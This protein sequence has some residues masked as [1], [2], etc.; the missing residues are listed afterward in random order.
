MIID[1]I[2]FTAEEQE[3]IDALTPLIDQELFSYPAPEPDDPRRVILRSWIKERN[4]IMADVVD[5]YVTSITPDYAAIIG[6]TKEIIFAYTAQDFLSHVEPVQDVIKKELTRRQ[7]QLD[8]ETDPK[9]QRGI[10]ALIADAQDQ[11]SNFFSLTYIGILNTLRQLTGPENEA[12]KRGGHADNEYISIL[13]SRAREIEAE[14]PERIAAKDQFSLFDDQQESEKQTQQQGARKAAMAI[15]RRAAMEKGALM[16]IGG[17][18]ASYSED[19]MKDAL[20][21][22]SIMRL[23]KNVNK[24]TAFDGTGKLNFLALGEN[25]LEGLESIHTAFLMAIVQAVTLSPDDAANTITF[26]VPTV[27]RDLGIDPR[28]YSKKREKAPLQEL[29]FNAMLERLLPFDSLVG[30]TP[31]GS[32]YRVLS[33][34]SYEQASETMTISTPYLFKLNEIIRERAGK[35]RHSQLNRLFHGDVVTEPN[36][37]AV[38]LA[39]RILYGIEN[40][41]ARADYKTYLADPAIKKKIITSTDEKGNRTTTTTVFDTQPQQQEEPIEDA[42][43]VTYKVKFSTLISDCPQLFD[44]LTAI[45]S[46]D[47]KGKAQAYNSKLKQVFEAAYRIIM[48]KSDA[49]AKYLDFSIPMTQRTHNGKRITSYDIPTKST[50]GRYLIITHNGKNKSFSQ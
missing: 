48:E 16:S 33:F 22:F 21:A 26:Y 38:E 14:L 32:Y 1:K 43:R 29:R 37:A 17:R 4:A 36:R 34:V 9:R 45:E 23:P 49:P 19:D 44:E 15:R 30:R 35:L 3:R 41:G 13:E 18:I 50:V 6:N 11:L 31:D 40:R 46:R 8:S 27:C 2:V 20:N 24:E 42:K 25:P 39:N 5:R 7:A 10:E 28:S 12:L 47:G